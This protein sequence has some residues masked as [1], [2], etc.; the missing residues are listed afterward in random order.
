MRRLRR[1]GKEAILVGLLIVF[2]ASCAGK[3]PVTVVNY[4]DSEYYTETRGNEIYHCMS[5][6]YVKEIMQAKI[7]QVN[8]R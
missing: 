2:G 5:E 1:H 6:Y 3:V 7:E 8:P 4:T